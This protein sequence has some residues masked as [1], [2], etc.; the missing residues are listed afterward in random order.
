MSGG[1]FQY[2][3]YFMEDI[4]GE[5][6]SLIEENGKTEDDQWG[7]V[8]GHDFSPETIARFQEASR[9]LRVA[10]N[11]VQR[12]DWLVSGDDGEDSFHSRW[13]E[14][15]GEFKFVTFSKKSRPPLIMDLD[16]ND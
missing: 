11:M 6:D 12:V 16:S 10:A 1:H 9:I 7:G 3:Q 5:I 13:K 4:A 14:E 15:V 2:R 8:S